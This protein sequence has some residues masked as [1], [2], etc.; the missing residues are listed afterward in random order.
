MSTDI[1]ALR[2]AGGTATSAVPDS[3]LISIEAER[4]ARWEVQV[5]ASDGTE[6]EMDVSSDGAT[7]T[8]GPTAKNE[9]EADKAKHRDRVQSAR[10]DYLAA[11]DKVLAEVPEGTI[12]ELNLDSDD[13]TTVWESDVID[14]SQMKHEVVIDAASGQ[15]LENKTGR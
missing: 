12:T 13:G 14:G 1:D 9:G 7:V 15:V 2:R 10:L 8:S 3:T 11:A 4:N 6:H 5:V